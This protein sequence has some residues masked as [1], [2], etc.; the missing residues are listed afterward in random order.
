MFENFH[1]FQTFNISSEAVRIHERNTS[2]NK[3]YYKINQEKF[4]KYLFIERERVKRPTKTATIRRTIFSYF[5]YRRHFE[6][7][8]KQHQS[9]H[10]KSSH[11]N[12]YFSK[13]LIIKIRF[14][15][16]LRFFDWFF[17]QIFNLQNASRWRLIF[18]KSNNLKV[19]GW[20]KLILKHQKYSFSNR[21]SA[22]YCQMRF[23][24]S[25][26]SLN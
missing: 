20:R 21:K 11:I 7:Q 3:T 15:R 19:S 25:A 24:C 17:L 10:S 16:F 8:R 18:Q 14:L 4:K 23:Q 2:L 5:W 26:L 22:L 13:K 6:N 9:F 1:Y 12:T